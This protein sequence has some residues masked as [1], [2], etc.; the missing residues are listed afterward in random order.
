MIFETL[1]HEIIDKLSDE[2]PADTKA[3]NS[4]IKK[5]S[6]LSL[7]P[8]PGEDKSK[9]LES[10]NGVTYILKDNPMQISKLNVSIDGDEGT[11]SYTNPRGDKKLYFGIKKYVECGFPETHYFGDTI[12][13][14]A[15]RMYRA[16]SCAAWTEKH[17]L[18]IRT[19]IIDDHLGNLTITLS[20]KGN[21][22]GVCMH[23]TA[24]FFLNEYQGFAGGY[25]E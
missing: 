20:F 24:E 9:I 15:N 10:I 5:C 3:Y 11:L 19:F 13:K 25:I 7:I 14:P 23:K 1:W 2:I 21:Q 8:I 17:K 18:V 6:S 4:L 12:N 22:I 16:T